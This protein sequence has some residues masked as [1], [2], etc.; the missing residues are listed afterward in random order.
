MQAVEQKATHANRSLRFRANLLAVLIALVATTATRIELLNHAAG[1]ILPAR[2]RR[3]D[4]T[5]VK[6]RQASATSK[7]GWRQTRGP[8]D[9]DG[10]PSTRPLTSDE[11]VRMMREVRHAQAAKTLLGLAQYIRVPLVLALAPTVMLAARATRAA[12]LFVP[13]RDAA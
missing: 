4:G 8:H 6:W 11:Q 5:P 1:G 12:G 2:E 10:Q 13:P 9:A 7:A 3:D